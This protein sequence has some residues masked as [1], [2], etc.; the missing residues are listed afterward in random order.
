MTDKIASSTLAAALLA[1]GACATAP[2]TT[3][4]VEAAA[5]ETGGNGAAG[6]HGKETFVATYDADGDGRV[7]RAEFDAERLEGFAARDADGDGIIH[8]EEYVAEYEAR[9]DADLAARRAAQMEQADGRFDALD[10]DEDGRMT[11]AEFDDSG[12][13]MFGELDTN[14]DGVVDDQDTAEAY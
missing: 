2:A 4:A 11:P 1:L 8:R 9:L 3:D 5:A 10:D 14:G 12:A 13:W 6:G 7:S